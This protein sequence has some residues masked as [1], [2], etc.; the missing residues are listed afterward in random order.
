M[1]WSHT[2]DGRKNI[3]KNKEARQSKRVGAMLQTPMKNKRQPNGT[4]TNGKPTAEFL[5]WFGHDWA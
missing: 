3:T 4:Q 1:K 2:Q 5:V